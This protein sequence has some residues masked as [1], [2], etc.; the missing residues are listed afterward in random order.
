MK[1]FLIELIGAAC[2]FV[3]P[4]AILFIAHGFNL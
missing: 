3:A 4:L 2:V 1:H